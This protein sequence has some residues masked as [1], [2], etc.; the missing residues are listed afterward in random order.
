MSRVMK[1]VLGGMSPSRVRSAASAQRPIVTDNCSRF[2]RGARLQA[3]DDGS[4][5]DSSRAVSRRYD[6]LVSLEFLWRAAL[7]PPRGCV[8]CGGCAP[9]Q[10]T[11]GS[12]QCR[13]SGAQRLGCVGVSIMW[14]SP[15]AGRAA[16][17]RLS[18]VVVMSS[19]ETRHASGW[20]NRGAYARNRHPLLLQGILSYTP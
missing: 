5:R 9:G 16:A 8:L 13:D 18:W 17:H 1:G 7:S 20:S 10:A 3:E 11:L 6:P 15:D 4:S 19:C 2:T 14:N 12:H